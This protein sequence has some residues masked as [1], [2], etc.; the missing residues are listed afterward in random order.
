M[1]LWQALFLGAL[2]GISEL[3]PVAS[4]GQTILF[5]ALL[6]WNLGNREAS[7]F[8]AFIVA[9]HLAT[10]IA[11]VIYFWKDWARVLAAFLG[12]AT[13]GKLVY[14]RD[15]KFAWMLVAGTVVVGAVGLV[16]EKKLRALFERPG[17]AWVVAAVLIVNGFIMLWADWL[18]RRSGQGDAVGGEMPAPSTETVVVVATM[19]AEPTTAV[20]ASETVIVAESAK[21]DQGA[22]NSDDPATDIP[23]ERKPAE[24]LTFI[25]AASIGATQSFALIPGISRSGVTIA[26][27]LLCGLSYEEATRFSFMLATPVIG[28]AALLKVPSLFKPQ[29]RAMLDVSIPAAILAGITAY[30]SA[31]F[32]M[33]YF[34]HHRLSPFGWYCILF[35]AFALAMLYHR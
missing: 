35:G 15:S 29:A 27:G 9:L 16:F 20:L 18:K 26:T 12:S 33:R 23:S 11:L 5:P 2:Q 24:A 34:R 25:E 31:R 14:D 4:L 32:L 7:N 30:L 28:L 10:A 8:L 13:R 21:S 1:Q 19:A 22:A 3:F 6:G 17:Y